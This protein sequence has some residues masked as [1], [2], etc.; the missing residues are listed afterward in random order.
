MNEFTVGIADKTIGKMPINGERTNAVGNFSGW[1]IWCGDEMP[2]DK[3]AFTPYCSE[4]LPIQIEVIRKYLS[5]APGY[6]FQVDNCGYE[7]V[8]FDEKLLDH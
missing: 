3:D 7:D 5:L 2:G 1:M 6:R 8:W 4:H